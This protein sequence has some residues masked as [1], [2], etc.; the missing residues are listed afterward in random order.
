MTEMT[1]EGEVKIEGTAKEYWNSKTSGYA[2]KGDEIKGTL[3][4]AEAGEY[5]KKPTTNYVLQTDEGEVVLPNHAYLNGRMIKVPVGKAVRIVYQGK[6]E[7]KGR[8]RAAPELY[9]VYMSAA[10]AQ[11]PPEQKEVMAGYMQKILSELKFGAKYF[12]DEI[13]PEV[14]I[15][16]T[17]EAQLRA[18]NMC[19]PDAP[20][21]F[22]KAL[23]DKGLVFWCETAQAKGYRVS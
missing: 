23:K 9:D 2:K 19:E 6:G 8:G 17:I 21:R 20:D 4:R 5:N 1:L 14:N 15:K 12:T 16:A 7:G 10:P 22:L 3:I 11:A 18:I 13:F